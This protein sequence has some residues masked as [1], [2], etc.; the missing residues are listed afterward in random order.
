MNPS[1][2]SNVC[3]IVMVGLLDYFK[4]QMLVLSFQAELVERL[5]HQA[6]FGLGLCLHFDESLL[7]YW[8]LIAELCT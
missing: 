2:A 8:L 5:A 6:L 3:F 7:R 1:L 4:V